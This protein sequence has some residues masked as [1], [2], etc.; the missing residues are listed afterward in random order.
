MLSNEFIDQL[1][2]IASKLD[3]ILLPADVDIKNKIKTLNNII[4]TLKTDHRNLSE[5]EITALLTKF[6][7][8]ISDIETATNHKLSML[9]FVQNISPK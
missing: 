6:Q 4:S 8:S 7:Q 3:D 9:D 5:P 2:S 1:V